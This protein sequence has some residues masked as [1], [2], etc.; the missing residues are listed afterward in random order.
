VQPEIRKLVVQTEEITRVGD[1]VI[2]PPARKAVAAAV[3][4][5]PYAGR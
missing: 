1:Q 5:N 4:R 3:V 2:D